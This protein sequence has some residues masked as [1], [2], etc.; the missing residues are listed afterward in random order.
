[1]TVYLCVS[2]GAIVC[3]LIPFWSLINIHALSLAPI[4]LIF[5]SLLQISIFRSYAKPDAE[6]PTDS[7][8]YTTR[9][10]DKVA[11]RI[12]MKY[13]SLC[14]LAILPPLC[15]LIVYG[16][17]ILKIALAVAFYLLSFLPVKIFV[18]WEQKKK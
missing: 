5:V 1:M 2:L 7:T 12:G 10:V 16:S 11:Y 9:E 4:V 17:G 6:L 13:H 8:S 3:S 15:A 14:K 18:R